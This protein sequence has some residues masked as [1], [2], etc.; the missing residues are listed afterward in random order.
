MIK[1]TSNIVDV[2]PLTKIPLSRNQS[3]S[4][5]ANKKLVEGTLV[6][7]SLFKRKVEGIV[8]G[9][10]PDFPRL[11]NIELKPI[12]EVIEETF[13]DKK[14]IELAQFVSDYYISPL[15]IVMKSFVPKRVKSRNPKPTTYNLQPTIEKTILTN[16]QKKVVA[17][18][19]KKTT[20]QKLQTKNFYLFGP[21]G[22]GKTEVYIHS[23]VKLKAQNSNLQFLIL[24]PEL[25]LTPQAIERY[26]AYFKAE[27]TVVLHSKISKGEFYSSWKKIKSGE[28]K[29]IIGSRMAVFAP[30]KKLGLIIVDEEQDI[31]F[32]Q[33]DMNPR[34]D[35]RTVA[36]KL[37]SLHHAKII[38][39]SATPSIEYFYQAAVNQIKLMELPLLKLPGK[40]ELK[41]PEVILV[42]LK[43]ERWQNQPAGRQGNYS[44][45]SKKLQV[46]IGYVLKHGLQAILFI[47][48]Q[49]MSSFSVC[50]A[51]KSVLACPKCDRALVY[52][53]GGAYQC[54]HCAFK[55]SITP[56][57]FKCQ[58]LAFSNIGF[59]T[60][61]VEREIQ[62]LFPAA[63]VVRADQ[64]SAKEPGF[65][66]KI[67]RNFS[68][69]KI[70]ILIGTQMISK[71]WDL[72][73][74]ALVG[75]I[76]ADNMLSLPDFSANERAYQNIVQVSGRTGRPNSK[77]RGLVL[78]QTFNPQSTIMRL[79]AEKDFKNLY[80][81]EKVARKT[82]NF[83][84]F[85][86]LV[87]IIFQD[88]N[89][90]NVDGETG[91]VYNILL[92]NKPDDVIIS[93]PHTGF[94]EKIR[95]RFRKQII[96]K[97]TGRD[98]MLPQKLRKILNFLPA[99][100]IIDVDPVS[101]L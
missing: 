60:Q 21:A 23:I 70:D 100:W 41:R 6:S 68:D 93:E 101:L 26:G 79:I 30:F 85:S 86:R 1:K 76:D 17:E 8:L 96:L 19:T 82:L 39:G 57:C 20:N 45:I 65:Q 27:D 48:R 81:I 58:G 52:D 66:K 98:N 50:A 11:G 29:I 89:L 5:L 62:N 55:T 14:Q 32:K 28:T 53:R 42:D 22:S 78:I 4:Y 37:A 71:G 13:L 44:S 40:P 80:E 63:R 25:T 75:I 51:C 38:F 97:L 7:I 18:I 88:Y 33:W 47:N 90:K 35:A 87:K 3:F 83:P 77:G 24:L 12:E 15:G 16:A 72:P 59:G 67:F 91:R 73:N 10:R 36:K 49:G 99:G 56:Q 9:A 43:K 64:Q 95:G 69:R 31:S 46:E 54:L 34:Y 94:V 92:E 84:P 61:K 74:V 2:V